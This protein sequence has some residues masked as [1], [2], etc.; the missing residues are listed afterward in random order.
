VSGEEAVVTQAMIE[1][2]MAGR[3]GRAMFIMDLG[4]PR[5]VEAGARRLYSVY[6]YNVDDLGEIVEQNK[7]AR[8][9]EI[10]RAEEII[11]QHVT[12]FAG[13]QASVEVN[14][15]LGQLR[16]ALHQQRQ[17]FLQERLAAM[18][19]LSPEDRQRVSRLTE[20]LIEQILAGPA[21]R[22]RHNRELRR[23]LEDIE[24]LRDV[25]GLGEKD[26]P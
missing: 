1:R 22:L 16:E 13:W 5:N 19:S 8:E 15:L 14:A 26:E 20:E 17:A 23:R 24:A 3:S 21:R 4:M 10:P 25:F 2:A 7:K 18:S 11:S 6:L 9:A 12:K